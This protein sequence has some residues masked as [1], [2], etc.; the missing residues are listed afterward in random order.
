MSAGAALSKRERC[1][2]LEEKIVSFTVFER[3]D[4]RTPP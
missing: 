1:N 4:D 2:L 3:A